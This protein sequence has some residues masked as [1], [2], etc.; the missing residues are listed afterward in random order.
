[1]WINLWPNLRYVTRDVA[2]V[3]T[4][5]HAG[6][7]AE[8][9]AP[10]L[11]FYARAFAGRSAPLALPLA[12][13]GAWWLWMHR[14]PQGRREAIILLLVVVGFP[15]ALALAAKRADR[16]VLPALVAAEVP[17][18]LGLGWLV[19]RWRIVGSVLAGLTIVGGG[20]L[21]LA[22]RPYALAWQNPL[23][24]AED[25]TQAGWG[26]G[27][28]AAAAGLNQHPLASSLFVAT[29]Y[30]QVFQEFFRGHTM[31]LSSR[32]DERVAFVVLYRNMRGRGPGA[33]ATE[34]LEE[35]AHRVPDTVVTLRGREV[36]WVYATGTPRLYTEH[37]GELVNVGA[38]SRTSS[39]PMVVE[40]GQV[41]RPAGAR[42]DGIR[43]V[44]STFSSRANAGV[45]TVHVRANPD[46]PDLRTVRL[47]ASRVA[48]GVWQEVRFAPI[49]DAAGKEFYVGLTANSRPGRGIT[50]RFQPV[51]L[52][53]EGTL[54]L[55]RPLAAG[56]KRRN[57]LRA[58]DLAVEPL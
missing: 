11:Q 42:W 28:E 7:A 55:R 56:E 19:T 12:A 31:H 29:W 30:P 47:D 33:V 8:S 27:L 44:F 36:A 21:A 16:Y 52:R 48:D 25:P 45:V 38:V 22:A 46:G 2:T 15:L 39:A 34:V 41:V 24:R 10:G 32:N 40:A 43:I 51:D 3:A 4:V 35:Y 6:E 58:G 57:H 23:V 5:P 37:V 13:A 49:A 26:E 14:R 18:A 17:A 9:H 1:M 20:A 50:V 53:P 54:I